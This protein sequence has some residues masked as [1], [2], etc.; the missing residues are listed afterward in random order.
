MK[1]KGFSVIVNDSVAVASLPSSPTPLNTTE[2]VP[3]VADAD[4]WI[5]AVVELPGFTGFVENDAVTPGGAL[6]RLIVTFLLY[7][8]IGFT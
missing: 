1:S 8:E 5:V 3:G 2:Y 6:I 7:P 4:T